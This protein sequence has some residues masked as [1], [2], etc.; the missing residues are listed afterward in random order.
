MTVTKYLTL[1]QAAMEVP[2][3]PAHSTVWRWATCG[4]RG[5]KL[6]TVRWGNRLWTTAEWLEEFQR[7]CS[8]TTARF[9]KS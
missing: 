7:D 1:P 8:Q 9:T 6:K 3:N 5:K 2:G 4:V